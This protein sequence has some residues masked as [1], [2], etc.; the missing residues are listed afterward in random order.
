MYDV[1]VVGGGLVGSSFA[2][3]LIKQNPQL[4]IVLVEQR[5]PDFSTNQDGFDN[6]IYAISP[7]NLEMLMTLD[8]KPNT[9]RFGT[10]QS[11]NV[12]GD[13][14]SKIEFD[15]HDCNS[16]Y[17]AKI[18]EYRNLQQS[19][20]AELEQ[21]SQVEFVYGTLNEIWDNDSVILK[22][23]D[24]F[25]QAK[26]LVAAD[27]ANS[28]VRRKF[29]F[30][31]EQIPYYQSGVVA[32]FKCEKPNLNVAH[33][34]FTGDGILAYLPLPNNQISIVWSTDRVEELLALSNEEFAAQ[35]ANESNYELGQL[36]VITRPAAFPLRLNLVND[37][38]RGH[39]IL[40]GDAAHT[41]HPLAG[42]GV[43]LGFGDAWELAKV[44][45]H[46]NAQPDAATLSR[47][48]ALRL[49][50][51]RKMQMTCHMLHR[52]FHNRN[53]IVNLVRNFGLN[54]VNNLTLLK[55]ML[56]R[57]AMTY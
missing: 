43:N 29:D 22:G 37:F 41:I 26:W 4:K 17:L 27:G 40:I 45:A 5:K 50:E 21:F 25:L 28:F 16:R 34:W 44:L 8:I 23:D 57:S 7:H 1:A 56:I 38:V 39:I 2:L 10:I 53:Q 32:N 3:S 46:T 48:V 19:I 24:F 36:E 54:L 30:T 14:N 6:K 51:V 42:Q 33:Q 9:E 55:K 35:V 15:S 13:R 12:R 11:M 47:F 31:V 52:L 18:I 49:A 20:L